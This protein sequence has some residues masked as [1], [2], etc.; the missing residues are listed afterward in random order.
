MVETRGADGVAFSRGQR[1]FMV[2]CAACHGLDRTGNPAGGFPSLIDVG[3][4][5]TREQIIQLTR[6]GAG[7]MPAFDQIAPGDR[8]AI[9]D[10]VLGLAPPSASR[11]DAGP[12]SPQPGGEGPA[13]AFAGFRRWTDQEGYPAIKPPWGTLNAVDLNTG[14]LKWKVPLGEYRQLT[15]LGIPPTGTEN[16]GGPVVTAGGIILIGA[17]AD[18]TIRAFDKE[19]G[20]ILWQAPLPF[21]GNATPSTYMVNGRQFVVISAGGTKSGR[22]SGGSLVAFALPDTLAARP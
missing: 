21:G 15:A 14:A 8:E 18:E 13:Y 4:R 10:Y 17:T 12:S 6:Q 19:T 1:G 16:Y 9:V 2:N 11:D 7:R 5:R 3:R 20:A 22:P